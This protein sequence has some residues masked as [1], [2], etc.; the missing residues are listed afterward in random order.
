MAAASDFPVPFLPKYEFHDELIATANKICTSG[1]G[2][3]AADESTGTIG[4]RFKDIKVENTRENRREY[5]KLLFTTPN[6]EK[7]ISGVILYEETLY[8]KD[9]DTL[10]VKALTDKGIVLGIKTDLGTKQLPSTDDE[11]YTQGLTDLDVRSKAYYKAGARFCKWR[12][13]LRISRNTPSP[14]AIY[15]NA[16]TL[17]AYAAISQANG[18]VPIV[19]PEILMDGDHSIEICQYWTEK[20]VAA[21]YK[22]LSEHHVLLE[23]TILKP[24]M[25]AP[26]EKCK[27]RASAEQVAK[28]TLT[29]LQRTI[30]P[31]VPGVT[32]LSGGHG[33]EDATMY[34]NALNSQAGKKPWNLSFSYGRA[35]QQSCLAVWGG[36]KENFTKAQETL[37]IR[38]RANGEASQGKYKGD[39]ASEMAKKSLFVGNYK[40]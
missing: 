12:A 32:F 31:A 23:G 27:V 30:P 15:E 36:K 10:L 1:K 24:N 16:H 37:F 35:L 26:G 21:C 25:V 11:T 28:A 18:L 34:L 33:E 38:C 2:I 22:A 9:G 40:Y 7:H 39:A 8:E 14:K 13:V 20:V 17:A 3:L 19:E 5:R 6:L 29:A 4:K